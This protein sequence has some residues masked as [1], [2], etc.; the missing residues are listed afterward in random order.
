MRKI[1]IS[2]WLDKEPAGM[3]TPVEVFFSFHAEEAHPFPSKEEAQRQ[4][5]I[6]DSFNV[7]VDWTEDGSEYVCKFQVEEY[8]P[9]AFVLFCDGPFVFKATGSKASVA[10]IT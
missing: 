7:R 9:Q 5:T 2:N 1:Y 10:K 8:P 6:F 3:T 4:R